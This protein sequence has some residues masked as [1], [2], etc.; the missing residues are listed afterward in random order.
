MIR[1]TTT[2]RQAN[3]RR[4]L[5]ALYERWPVQ[6]EQ[7]GINYIQL[8]KEIGATPAPFQKAVAL[9]KDI[10]V[11]I[12]RLTYG[13]GRHAYWTLALPKDEALD[14]LDAHHMR[15]RTT[16][17]ESQPESNLVAS[18]GDDEIV[19]PFDKLKPLRRDEEEALVAAARQYLDRKQMLNE[20][21][22][23]LERAGIT[24]KREAFQFATDERLEHIGLVLPVIDRLRRQVEA[25]ESRIKGYADQ[26]APLND[27]IREL[28]RENL[29]L[30]RIV[31]R[32]ISSS[33]PETA[34]VVAAE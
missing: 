8:A 27:R 12:T 13:R 3:E 15:E 11:L 9:Y 2:K 34:R 33:V 1:S 25:L 10:G 4:W 26:Q 30:R 28:E 23:Q 16:M 20:T 21:I 22:A 19:R 5:E 7:S 6:E 14:R 32:G 17:T 29:G 18:V 24:A 31:E